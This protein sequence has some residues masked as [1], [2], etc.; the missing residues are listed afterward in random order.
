ML[1]ALLVLKIFTLLSCLFGYVE[2]WIDKKAM[3][4]FKII[5][6]QSGHQITTIHILPNISRSKGNQA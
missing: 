3:G 6:S 4:N 2:K 1:E 5:T